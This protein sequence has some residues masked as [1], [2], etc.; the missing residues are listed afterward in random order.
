MSPGASVGEADADTDASFALDSGRN[1]SE[2]TLRFRDVGGSQHADELVPA[3]TNDWIV[4][5]QTD[6]YL[7][8]RRLQNLVTCFVAL[9]IVYRLESIYVDEGHSQWVV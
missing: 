9:T 6:A 5:A 4:R 2:S 8:D 3:V 1:R 7:T